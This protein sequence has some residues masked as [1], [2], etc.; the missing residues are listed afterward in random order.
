MSGADGG[1][2]DPRSLHTPETPGQARAWEE[3]KR[4]YLRLGLCHYCAAQAAYGHAHGFAWVERP[5]PG[6]LPVVA[7][8]EYEA[9]NG[10]RKASRERLRGRSRSSQHETAPIR[11]LDARDDAAV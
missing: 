10:W 6:C 4:Q 7:T 3:I 1:G 8:F 5:R 9:P 11:F 2:R